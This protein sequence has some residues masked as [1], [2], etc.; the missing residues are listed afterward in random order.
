VLFCACLRFTRLSFL[1]AS[2][3]VLNAQFT[4]NPDVEGRPIV[5]VRYSPN[6]FLEPSDLETAQPLKTGQPLRREEVARAIDSLFATGQFDDISVEASLSSTG[7]GAGVAIEFRLTPRAFV[8]H[9]AFEGKLPAPPNATE[10]RSYSQLDLAAPFRNDDIGRAVN[11]MSR[12]FHNNGLEHTT[13]QPQISHSEN[14]DQ[15]FVTFQVH[16]SRRAKYEQPAVEGDTL[17]PDSVILRASGWRIPIIHW[18][19]QVTQARTSAGVRG[20]L[21]KYQKQGRLT[22]RVENTGT[23]YDSA[24][25]RMKP[26]LTVTPGPKVEVKAME[27]RVSNGIL[28][29]YVPVYEE[30]AL[31]NDLLLEGK[32]NLQDYFQ[33]QGYYE[34]DV[35][36]RVKPPV[37]DLETVE[38]VIAKG[39][40]RK[41]AAVAV[42]GNKYFNT[43]TIRERMFIQPAAFNLRHG[44][45]SEAF[46]RKDEETIAELY[47]SNGFRDVKVTT[48]TQNRYRDKPEEIAVTVSIEE[49]PQWLIRNVTLK[50]AQQLDVS[51]IAKQFAA[52]SGQPF[53]ESSLAT[54]RRS[55]LNYCYE[56]G[57]PQAQFQASWSIVEP[58]RVDVAYSL[59]EGPRQYVR[60]VLISGATTTR[61]SILLRGITLKPGDEL[62]PVEETRI[63]QRFD[64]L[65]IFA[66]V[67]TAIENPEGTAAHKYVLYDFQESNRYTLNVG[68]GAQIAQFGTPSSTSL[69]SPGG[70]TGFSPEFLFDVSRLNFLGLGHTVSLRANY[71]TIEKKAAL[72]YLQPRFRNFEGRNLSYTLLFDNTLDVRTFAAKREQAS[73]QLSQKFSRSLTGQLGLAYRRVSVSSVIIPVLLIPQILQPVRIGILTG[74]LIQ[75]RRNN[76]AEPSHGLYNTIDT[77]IATKAFGSQRSFFR[78]LARNAT[79]YR[80]S[81]SLILARQTQ[82]GVIAPFSPPAGLS[83]QASVPLPERFFGGGADSLRAFPFNQAGPRDTGAAVTPGGPTSQPT[84]FPL[85]GN[86]LFFNNVE[87]RFPLIGNNIRGVFFHDMGNVYSSLGNMSFAFHQRNLQDF[88]YAVHAVGLGIRYRTPIGPV[89]ADL[90][91]SINPP[92]YNGFGGTPTELLNCNPNIPLSSLPSYCQPS[93]QSISHFQFFFSIGQT[94]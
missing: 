19:R 23:E 28:R 83:A 77:G 9:V 4:S 84:G 64:D 70:T 30:R 58:Q 65:G 93:R 76:P 52:L 72:T 20:I 53:S 2:C 85:G 71:S 7:P 48:T 1:V 41:V 60:D 27:A 69:A 78:V 18:W 38:Y 46:R 73:V 87:L 37:N 80:L 5:S 81:K 79:Y 57:F 31:D 92:A 91:Y 43:D 89:R 44:R 94:F 36:F 40:R 10:L 24:T 22:A 33:S 29:R 34:V 82:F 68:I 59:T 14:G 42:N 8:R 21:S 49:G 26:H 17:L 74:N 75:D 62:S 67:D 3:T 15:V 13:V 51:S 32:R 54:D 50:G 47:R 86:A 39:L 16:E 63:Q 45:Y 25:Q 56:R 90:A 66:R 11:S 12:L 61:R 55:I 6:S 35:D 88:D